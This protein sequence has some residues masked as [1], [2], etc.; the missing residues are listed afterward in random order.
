MTPGECSTDSNHYDGMAVGL[1][2]HT[3][4]GRPS[5][6]HERYIQRVHL[7]EVCQKGSEKDTQFRGLGIPEIVKPPSPVGAVQIAVRGKV[8]GLYL[9]GL[10]GIPPVSVEPIFDCLYLMRHSLLGC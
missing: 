9:A 1:S 3:L 7:F 6:Y 2:R 4:Y 10:F 8:D 5:G